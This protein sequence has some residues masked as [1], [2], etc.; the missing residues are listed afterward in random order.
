MWISK[1]F[2]PILYIVDIGMKD[3]I[4]PFFVLSIEIFCLIGESRAR[5]CRLPK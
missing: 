4:I 3:M 5:S 2:E 1:V